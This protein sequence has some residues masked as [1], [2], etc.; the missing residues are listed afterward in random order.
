MTRALLLIFALSAC[1][2]FPEVDAGARTNLPAPSLL[3]TDQL[4]SGINQTAP[5]DPL[6][7]PVAAL[8]AR[9]A[10]LRSQAAE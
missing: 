5:A 10:A 9:A 3:P 1:T 6:A 4:I 2:Q 7:G 8:N